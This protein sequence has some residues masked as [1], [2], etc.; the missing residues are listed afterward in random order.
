MA[1]HFTTKGIIYHVSLPQP[2]KYMESLIFAIFVLVLM[3]LCILGLKVLKLF[4]TFMSAVKVFV[5]W[6]LWTKVPVT[7]IFLTVDSKNLVVQCTYQGNIPSCLLLSYEMYHFT[8]NQSET[9]QYDKLATYCI[10]VIINTKTF[11]KLS[12]D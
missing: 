12:E 9:L 1:V 2:M 7:I 10:L 11:S 6:E 3:T 8:E 4:C 5:H